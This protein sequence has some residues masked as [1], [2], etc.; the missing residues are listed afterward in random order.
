M[1]ASLQGEGSPLAQTADL[2]AQARLLTMG[3]A[4]ALFRRN[5]GHLP[6]T[7]DSLRGPY[8]VTLPGDP[9]DRAGA[10]FKYSSSRTADLFGWS[11]RRDDQGL[12]DQSC[13]MAMDRPISVFVC[14]TER[15]SQLPE[16]RNGFRR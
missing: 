6:A 5:E 10:T 13:R 9:W 2:I 3:V 4:V 1:A 7:L 12:F 16:R 14:R 11:N 15:P 8:L